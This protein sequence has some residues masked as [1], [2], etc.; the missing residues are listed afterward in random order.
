M[1]AWELRTPNKTS[2]GASF[3]TKRL[4][5]VIDLNSH[6]PV[7]W[8][9]KFNIKGAPGQQFSRPQIGVFNLNPKLKL[10]D[11]NIPVKLDGTNA[12]WQKVEIP[13]K[14]FQENKSDQFDSFAGIKIR[15]G[16]GHATPLFID[17]IS[18]E[19]K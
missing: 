1:P 12:E 15:S 13:L 6:E 8:V 18:L 14:D 5:A 16:G 2:G 3:R 19:P 4:G 11:V 9:L 7:D 17:N 10:K